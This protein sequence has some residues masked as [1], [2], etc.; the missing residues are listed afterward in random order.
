MLVIP[1]NLG[2]F[3]EISLRVLFLRF[4]K[5]PE[6]ETWWLY[7]VST[8]AHWSRFQISFGM[9]LYI[10]WAI[11]FCLCILSRTCSWQ[12]TETSFSHTKLWSH[13]FTMASTQ[14]SWVPSTNQCRINTRGIWR[15]DLWPA[16]PFLFSQIFLK[17]GNVSTLNSTG[18]KAMMISDDVISMMTNRKGRD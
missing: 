5:I 10:P 1:L 15:L 8:R 14:R 6:I 12:W 11:L 7:T 13:H 18:R 9:L 16:E 3:L 2:E 4:L 17:D